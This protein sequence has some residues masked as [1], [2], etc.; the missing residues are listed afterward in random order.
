MNEWDTSDISCGGESETMR[1]RKPIGV[2]IDGRLLEELNERRGLIPLSRY[3]EL[4]VSR[5]LEVSA[6]APKEG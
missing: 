5:G 1:T 3:L 2:T 6:K 4:L